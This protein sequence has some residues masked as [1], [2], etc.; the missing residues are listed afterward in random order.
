M[1]PGQYETR[2]LTGWGRTAPTVAS[3][4]TPT[5]PEDVIA[6]VATAGPRGVIARGLGRSYGDPAQ[7]AG[8]LVVDM[9]GLNRIHS[10]D[11][12]S[13]V[14]VLDAGVN[15]D[16]L[17]RA[18]LPFGLWVP[19][20][21]GTRQVTIGGAIGSDIHGKNHHSAGS[22]GNHVLAMDLLVADGSVRTLTPD[23]PEAELF[24]ATVGGMGLTGI[25]LR[26]TVALK[27]TES[28][29]F[30]SDTD[31]T[32]DLD[33]T[34]AVFSNGTDDSYEYSMAWFDSISTDGRLGRAVFSRGS[35]A[36]LD[37]LPKKY[38]KDPLRFDAPQ[39]LTLPD[40]FP[41]GL[42][43]KLTFKLLGEA[44]YR[45][46]PKQSRGQVMNL[47]A[48]YHPLDMF[49]EWNRAYGTHGFL[50]YQFIIPFS[51]DAEL[52]SIVRQMAESGHVSFLNVFKRMGE[53]N[54]APLSFPQPG[55]TITVDFPITPGL[56]EFCARLDEQV[57]AAG[58]RLYLAK[59]SRTAPE[60]FHRMYPGL[61]QWR[62]TRH[63]VDPDGLFTSDQSRRLGL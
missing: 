31:R 55:W 56:H 24:W 28:A 4:A 20:L 61:D 62:K 50:Q 15:L 13:G 8:G 33:E 39:L 21:P 11:A 29:Y 18:A 42:A 25:V 37:E 3:V 45:K 36:K 23:G 53:G 38:R 59:E 19:V 12:D 32:A 44:W 27:H 54:Q 30:I 2:R 26:A 34:L 51:A 63:A 46:A 17:M 7:N 9:T 22:F 43:N 16:Q 6:A 60:T 5:T 1:E 41:N 58:G 10:I 47:T 52:R 57:L 35:L 48:F 40:V 49:G 14:A